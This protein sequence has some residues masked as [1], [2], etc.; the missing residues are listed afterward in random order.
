M[1]VEAHLKADDI[2]VEVL[3]VVKEAKELVSLTDAQIICSGGRGLGNAEGFELIK[4][5]ANKVG[6][7]VG[8]SRAAVDSGWIDA[9]HQ[10]GQTG[11]TVKPKI[12]FACGILRGYTASGRDADF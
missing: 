10:V 11:T 12:Y 3:D 7:V 6:G 2:N 8:A 1:K 9:S 4:E 5:F